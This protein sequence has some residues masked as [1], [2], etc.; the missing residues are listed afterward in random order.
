MIYDL[1]YLRRS[2]NLWDSNKTLNNNNSDN[3][4]IIYNSSIQTNPPKWF[5]SN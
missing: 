5:T 1:N 4:V 2:N 3:V